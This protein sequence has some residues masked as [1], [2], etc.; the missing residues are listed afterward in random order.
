MGVF[1]QPKPHFHDQLYFS[2]TVIQFR[3]FPLMLNILGTRNSLKK[4]RINLE[5]I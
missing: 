1:V 5:L 3:L 4:R 2:V